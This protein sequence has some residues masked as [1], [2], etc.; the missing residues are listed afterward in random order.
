MIQKAVGRFAETELDDETVL[1]NIDTGSFHALK[2]TG[3]VI[4]QMID[5]ARDVEAI[6]GAMLEQFDVDSATCAAEVGREC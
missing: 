4:W 3:R 1:M 6:T 2:G 5:G